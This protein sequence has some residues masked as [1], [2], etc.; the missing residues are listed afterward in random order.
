M[1]LLPIF[2][3]VL[4]FCHTLGMD[5]VNDTD[6]VGDKLKDLIDSD[7]ICNTS[8]MESNKKVLSRRKRFIVF[9]EGS[10]LQLGKIIIFNMTC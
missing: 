2:L 3:V 5:L 6:K 10:S 1:I 4:A 7:V 9:P 8:D